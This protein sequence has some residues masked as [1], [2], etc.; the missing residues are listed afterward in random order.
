MVKNHLRPLRTAAE[1]GSDPTK[2]EDFTGV[3]RC[4]ATAEQPDVYTVDKIV[5]VRV[6]SGEV[7]YRVKW[8]GYTSRENTWEPSDNLIAH[9]AEDMVR[10][11]FTPHSA[12]VLSSGRWDPP[13]PLG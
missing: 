1:V 6:T 9:G 2:F 3:H 8:R 5:D 13:T 10:V 12:S 11:R 4:S 7:E